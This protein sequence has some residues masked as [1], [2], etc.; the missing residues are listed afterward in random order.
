MVGTRVGSSAR[1]IVAVSAIRSMA[2]VPVQR[3]TEVS[4]APSGSLA[5]SGI[6]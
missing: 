6:W 4:R 5:G 1:E 2:M 3:G